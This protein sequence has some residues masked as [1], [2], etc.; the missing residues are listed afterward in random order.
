MH[1]LQIEKQIT[2]SKGTNKNAAEKKLKTYN[3]FPR[4]GPMQ[5]IPTHNGAYDSLNPLSQ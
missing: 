1:L 5:F 2:S 4:L 3:L